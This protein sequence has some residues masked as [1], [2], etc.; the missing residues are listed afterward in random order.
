[1]IVTIDGPAGAGKSTAARTLASRLRFAY[2]D[3]GA[4]FR[5]VAL[6]AQNANI[7]WTDESGLANLV[8]SLC[9][10]MLPGGIVI[11]DGVD[12][13]KRI[14]DNDISQGA[15]VVA[16][17]TAVRLQLA[18]MQ[19][20]IASSGAIVSEGRDQGTVVFP[21]AGCKFYLFADPEERLRRR[22]K[23]LESRGV[24]VD[25]EELRRELAE[26]NQRDEQ[27][28]LAPLRAAPDA[29]HLDSTHLTLEEVVACMEAK[30]RERLR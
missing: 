7:A 9:L 18:D 3:T 28:K 8:P 11:L 4:M 27:R 24:M 12:V 14:R 16:V 20:Q 30:V 17:S 10:E 19:R 13:T 21:Q 25:V 5:S 22:V 1:M 2:L 29:V 26:R 23:E 15:S 6:A